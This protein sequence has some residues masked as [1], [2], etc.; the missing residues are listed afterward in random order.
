MAPGS[1]PSR[2][3]FLARVGAASGLVAIGPVAAPAGLFLPAASAQQG[4]SAAL[5]AFAESV[6]L[7]AVTA[8]EAGVE[9]LSESLAPVLLTLIGHHQEH[10][11]VWAELAGD[12]ATGEANVALLDLLQ[13]AI[14]GFGSQ[15]EVLRFARDLENQLSVTCGHLL[16]TVEDAAAIEAAATIL[17]VEASHA[18][19][20][21]YE[22]EEGIE[23]WFPFGS[24]ESAD[25]AFGLDPAAFPVTP[26]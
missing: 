14:E 4:S 3:A 21:S 11:S 6:E 18:A 22:L 20:L 2:R 1:S 15:N 5:A 7:V 13:P 10:A 17:P 16:R 8:Y 26:A 19:T 9:L 24:L 23:L 12:A 25:L